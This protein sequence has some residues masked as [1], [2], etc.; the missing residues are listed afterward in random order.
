MK[1]LL[2]ALL[3]GVSSNVFAVQAKVIG[4]APITQTEYVQGQTT[5]QQVQNC[6]TTQAYGYQN[7]GF[8][9]Q[10]TNAIFGSTAGLI[11]AVAGIAI[12]NNV[13]SG[14]GYEKAIGAIVGS[15][16]ANQMSQSNRVPNT[17]T[18]CTTQSIPVTSQVPVQRVVGYNV[19]VV[20]NDRVYLIQRDY[21]PQVGSF[22]EV[23]VLGVR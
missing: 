19:N 17:V 8:I 3:I 14:G 6:N 23:E 4:V 20:Y 15:Q 16:V 9:N 11:G 18:Q 12:G 22:I 10:G 2:S 21:S 1:A 7:N 13:G 5:Y